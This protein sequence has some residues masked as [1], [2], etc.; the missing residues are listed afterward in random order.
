MGA[1]YPWRYFQ[2]EECG[3]VQL[4]PVPSEAQLEEFYNFAYK[5][6]AKRHH[7]QMATVGCRMLDLLER[8]T[9]GR[10][11]LEIGCA[12][13][14]FLQLAKVRGWSGVGIEASASAA[15]E[16]S[17]AGLEVYGGTIQSNLPSLVSRKFDVI[18]MWH[19]IEHFPDA[20]Q[21]LTSLSS[22]LT[23][24]GYLTLR[25]PNA[26]STGARL[27]GRRWEWFYAPEHIFL[28]T[29]RGIRQLLKEF[30]L[31]VEWISS[32]RGDAQTLLS[33]AV[34]AVGSLAIGHLRDGLGKT[35]SALEKRSM[36]LRAVHQQ[37]S[38]ITNVVGKPIDALLGLNGNNL[39]GSELVVL[40]RKP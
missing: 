1:N 2:C 7:R 17:S 24:G 40:A 18:A 12:Y 14:S 30:D 3:G 4:A 37:V 10:R 21:V 8:K 26:E 6:E 15:L 28:Y 11:L 31:E 38:S 39:R 36:G 23:S 29:A 22:L 16:A 19:V 32:Q 35:R 34:T 20:R 13:G 9:S 33:Q 27:L 5:V 25:T